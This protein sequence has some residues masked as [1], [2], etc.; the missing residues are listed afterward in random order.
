MSAQQISPALP[1]VV[2][3]ALLLQ[4]C[5]VSSRTP[6]ADEP[7]LAALYLPAAEDDGQGLLHRFAPCFVV[8]DYQHDHNRIGAPTAEPSGKGGDEI[9]IDTSRPAIFALAQNFTSGGKDFTNLI[10]RVHFPEVPWPHLTFGRNVGLLVYVT[11]NDRQQPVLVTTLHTCGCYLAMFPTSNLPRASW[12]ADW[13]LGNQEVYGEILPNQLPLDGKDTRGRLLVTLRGNTH[14]VKALTFTE[15]AALP[16]LTPIPA[17]LL[18]MATLDQLPVTEGSVS[19]FE[20]GGWR[21]GYVKGSS[22]PLERLFIS[23]WALDPL[24]GEDKSLGP[25]GKTGATMYTSLKFWERDASDIWEFP[26]FLSYW[27]W[28]LDVPPGD[29]RSEPPTARSVPPPAGP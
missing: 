21:K 25:S 28:R 27:G 5:A 17:R 16:G 2:L 10:Y 11:L 3:L 24:V 4:G 26:K 12:P 1:V 7:T 15:V 8:E 6:K 20:Q 13:P 19:F 22:K 14:R 23:W 9:H 18:P 29:S